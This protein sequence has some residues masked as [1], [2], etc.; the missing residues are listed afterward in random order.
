LGF[1]FGTPGFHPIAFAGDFLE[2]LFFL[3]AGFLSAAGVFLAAGA[4]V[5]VF[6]FTGIFFAGTIISL[7]GRRKRSFPKQTTYQNNRSR[8]PNVKFIELSGQS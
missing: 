6:F 2:T 7:N 5:E 8:A 3:A 4:F 1:S